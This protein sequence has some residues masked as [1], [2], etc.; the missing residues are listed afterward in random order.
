MARTSRLSG[1]KLSKKECVA[2]RRRARRATVPALLG[3]H[4]RI[5]DRLHRFRQLIA[6]GTN[7]RGADLRGCSFYKADLERADFT[8]ACMSGVSLE[9]ANLDSCILKDAQLDGAF[10]TDSVSEAADIS[11][12]DFSEA[13]IT[14]RSVGIL[15][16]RPDATG[17]NPATSVL[18]R[19]SLVCPG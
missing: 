18:T 5:P 10:F 11:G 14:P 2:A 6:K 8:G 19:D 17:K 9:G 4:T 7:F 3:S 15:C 12:A 13:L 16:A 1:K